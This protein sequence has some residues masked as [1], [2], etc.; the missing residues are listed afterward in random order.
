MMDKHFD[1]FRS[2]IIG[3]NEE[4]PSPDGSTKRIVYADWTASGRNYAPIE[5][6][7]MDELMP[8]VGNTHTETNATGMAMTHAYLTARQI[9]KQHVNADGKD[10]IITAGS[11]MTSLVN[12]LQRIL[13]L[14]LPEKYFHLPPNDERPV[15]FVTHMEHHSNQTSWLET[16]A[17]VEIINATSD[18][19]VDV[20]HLEELV[21]KYSERPLKIASVTA[22]SNVTGIQ[23]PYH[24]I[25]GIMHRAGGYCFVDFACSGPYVD[26]D[27]H[28]DNEDERLDAVFLSPHKFLGGPGSAGVM[29]F[30]SELYDRKIPDN[31]GGGTVEWTNPWGLHR[32]VDDIES[33]EDGGTPAFLQTI[34][35]ALCVKLKE[36]M[37]TANIKE[38]EDYL[39]GILW[40]K[41]SSLPNLHI[42]ASQ[43]RKRLPIVSFYIDDL[44]YNLTVKILN[45]RFGIQSRGGCSCAGTYGHYLF[46]VDESKSKEIDG[47]I[48]IGDFTNKLGW[49]RIS[50]HPTM[51]DQDVHYIADSVA[52]VARNHTLWSADYSYELACGGETTMDE[53]VDFVLKEKVT[54]SLMAPLTNEAV[55]AEKL[56]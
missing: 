2:G 43:H 46:D 33:R 9:I 12:K 8:L 53:T 11:G 47:Q 44:H 22:C 49:V 41:I 48:S 18:G 52:A 16:I 45:D 56:P 15:I 37:G 3:I 14:R 4:I 51:T 27:M 50:L 26:I 19:L 7:I 17:Q 29:V 36:E 10:I 40:D 13:N 32:F 38:R 20:S 39:L 55:T 31:P 54:N 25:A 30:N 42:L 24:D 6:R 5:R 21:S 23:T 28:P 1:A 35:T 34:K